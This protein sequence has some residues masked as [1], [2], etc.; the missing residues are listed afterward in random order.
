MLAAPR[1]DTLALYNAHSFIPMFGNYLATILV[2][3]VAKLTYDIEMEVQPRAS[4]GALFLISPPF[5]SS[6]PQSILYNGRALS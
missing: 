4:P 3:P 6:T 5:S 2:H 1:R